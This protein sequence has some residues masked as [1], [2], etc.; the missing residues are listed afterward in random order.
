MKKI[1][2]IIIILVI[3]VIIIGGTLIFFGNKNKDK[4]SK[5][6]ILTTED[7]IGYTIN[8]TYDAPKDIDI[9]EKFG[10]VTNVMENSEYNTIKSLTKNYISL[11]MTSS[12]TELKT[13][14][15]P[16]FIKKYNI[17]DKNILG[18]SNIPTVDRLLY[19]TI[20]LDMKV[21]SADSDTKVYIVKGKVRLQE[22][23]KI[24]DFYIMIETKIQENLYSI[25]P[26]R[27]ITANGYD[28]LKSG[29]IVNNYSIETIE[30]RENNSFVYV[31]KKSNKE[32]ATQYFDDFKERI[33]YYKD[34]AYEMLDSNYSK[35]RFG[36]KDTFYNYLEDNK[37]SLN[38]M[39][40]DKYK[41]IKNDNYIDYI[42][43]DRHH[44]IYT[45]RQ[46]KENSIEDY[47]VFLD[48]YTI[49]S[50]EDEKK[51]KDLDKYGKAKINLNK[52]ISMI[53]N[54]DYNQIYKHLDTN[55]KSNMLKNINELKAFI[56]NN[57][58]EINSI[59]IQN[60]EEKDNYYA[61]SCL[62]I[63]ERNTK[64]NKNI[65]VIISKTDDTNFTM[66]FGF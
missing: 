22:N 35:S 19:K 16:S 11:L 55:F 36:N 6:K 40:I 27:Y 3:I 30:N 48:N 13:L 51:Y 33:L 57:C 5:E 61:F 43:A 64:E 7:K 41:V 29:D 49:L 10:I 28:K 38:L 26:E 44:N 52:I 18:I 20:I 45:F 1:K 54:K 25:Y 9:K 65:S 53:N 66:S 62:L 42:C 63:N 39:Y 15:A 8:P 14:L 12:K 32:M 56:K 50:K 58:Y 46:Y 2:I 4:I 59:E 17:S 60:S 34:I 24:Y 31:E 23:N 21:F 47:T 37:I